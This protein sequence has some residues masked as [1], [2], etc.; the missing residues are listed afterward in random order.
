MIKK[1]VYKIPEG[2]LVKVELETEKGK[3]KKIKITGDFFMHPEEMIEK[4][5]ENLV[6]CEMN[7]EVLK[8]HL[9]NFWKSYHIDCFGINSSGLAEAILMA[10]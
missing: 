4:L 10:N 3:I 8:K 6:G 7:Q 9:D 2:K 1:S 5:E